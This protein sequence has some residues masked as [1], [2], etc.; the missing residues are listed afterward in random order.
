M[1]SKYTPPQ[2]SAQVSGDDNHMYP[3]VV[4]K[5]KAVPPKLRNR[6]FNNLSDVLEDVRV[7]CSGQPCGVGLCVPT[8]KEEPQR[9]SVLSRSALQA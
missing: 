6:E 3:N 5:V 1:P 7:R 4:P 2:G 9:W 8:S